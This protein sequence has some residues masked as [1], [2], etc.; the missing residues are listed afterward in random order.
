MICN[1]PVVVQVSSLH[2]KIK[3]R[4]PF[5]CCHEVVIGRAFQYFQ[6]QPGIYNQGAHGFGLWEFMAAHNAANIAVQ[7]VDGIAAFR[8]AYH[9][10]CVGFQQVRHGADCLLLI[11]EVGKATIADNPVKN[12]IPQRGLHNI[13]MKQKNAGKASLAMNPAMRL[14]VS[15]SS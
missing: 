11:V 9:Q 10:P 13:G 3:L 6:C 14:L 12:G 4:H 15:A 5:L 2:Y 7:F 8:V 1:C